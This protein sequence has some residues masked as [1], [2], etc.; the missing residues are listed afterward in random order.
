MM[1]WI[2]ME[3]KKI[4]APTFLYDCVHQKTGIVTID[5]GTMVVRC[6]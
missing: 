3:N 4:K 5:D 1:V 6:D 2:W